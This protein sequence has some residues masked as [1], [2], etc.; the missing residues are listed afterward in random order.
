MERVLHKLSLILVLLGLVSCATSQQYNE[1]VRGIIS[2]E[3]DDTLYKLTKDHIVCYVCETGI[4]PNSVAD[5]IAFKPVVE[6]CKYIFKNQEF[7]FI[8]QQVNEFKITT[9]RWENR[10]SYVFTLEGLNFE[11]SSKTKAP[12]SQTMNIYDN[13][14]E[15]PHNK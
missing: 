2:F 7:D 11:E 3:L 10:T 14:A 8:D 9:K 15:C 5:L 4:P 6:E 13:E 1:N 12:I